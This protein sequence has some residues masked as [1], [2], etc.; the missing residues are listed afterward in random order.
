VIVRFDSEVRTRKPSEQGNKSPE[1]S[2]VRLAVDLT[3]KEQL[4]YEALALE[5][6]I[7]D[8]VESSYE[9]YHED[10]PEK[11]AQ[12]LEKIKRQYHKT[13]LMPGVIS[14]IQQVKGIISSR[15]KAPKDIK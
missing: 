4:D 12:K 10:E 13:R 7:F 5:K 11:L 2:I 3:E 15:S 9:A 1:D 8:E 14:M 6:R